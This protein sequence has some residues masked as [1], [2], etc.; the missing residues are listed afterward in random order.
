MTVTG[1]FRTEKWSCPL[2]VR[3]L[4]SSPWPRRRFF[5]I[6]ISRQDIGLTGAL[7][8]DRHFEQAGFNAL[9]TGSGH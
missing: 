2:T 7:T 9:L 1:I 6:R 4:K 5:W 8:A 3:R